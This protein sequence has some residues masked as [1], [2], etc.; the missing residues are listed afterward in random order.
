[1]NCICSVLVTV[2]PDE[3]S[4][5][6]LAFKCFNGGTIEFV[7]LSLIKTPQAILLHI[8]TWYPGTGMEKIALVLCIL[9]WSS[10]PSGR[11]GGSEG[12]L[13]TFEHLGAGSWVRIPINRY[14][15]SHN[16][17]REA[18]ISGV[19]NS[20]PAKKSTRESDGQILLATKIST[21]TAAKG[22]ADKK[23]KRNPC[24]DLSPVVWPGYTRSTHTKGVSGV[25]NGWD[26]NMHTTHAHTLG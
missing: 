2:N 21:S 5:R 6:M 25:E 13:E 8:F 14:F 4:V 3:F 17:Y 22:G 7:W 20:W 16:T 11:S 23:N 19:K 1:M 18:I 26:D 12:N 24:V 15:F 10:G 9:L